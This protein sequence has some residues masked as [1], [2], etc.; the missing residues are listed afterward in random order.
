M[1]WLSCILIALG[2]VLLSASTALLLG[3]VITVAD[4]LEHPRAQTASSA[5]L[6]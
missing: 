2:W 3:A 1:I 4:C 5:A 6:R